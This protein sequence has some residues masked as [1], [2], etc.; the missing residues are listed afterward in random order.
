MI[1]LSAI[2]KSGDPQAAPILI[3]FW[4]G[5]GDGKSQLTLVEAQKNLFDGEDVAGDDRRK[6]TSEEND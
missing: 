1:Y 2:L 4:L 5:L 6:A 3:P